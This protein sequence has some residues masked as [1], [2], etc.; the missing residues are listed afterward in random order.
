V[1]HD[2]HFGPTIACG[3]IGAM[4]EL[5]NDVVVRLTPLTR[6]DAASMLRDLRIFPLL[7]GYRGSRACDIGALEDLLVRISALVQ[8]HP[9]VSELECNPVVAGPSDAVVLDA[10]VRIE[11]EAQRS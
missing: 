3:A 4:V 8:D 5:R 11:A 6:S 1:V 9:C 10:R 2:P 7:S